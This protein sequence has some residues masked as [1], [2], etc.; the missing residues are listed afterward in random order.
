MT[1]LKNPSLH[2][3]QQ[4]QKVSFIIGLELISFLSLKMILHTLLTLTETI[5][6]MES[7][8][9]MLKY[10]PCLVKWLL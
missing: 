4:R 6:C 5:N 1:S 2:A 10:M 3:P 9:S 8:T 7:L